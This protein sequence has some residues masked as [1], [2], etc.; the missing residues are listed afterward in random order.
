MAVWLVDRSASP[1]RLEARTCW[2]AAVGFESDGDTAWGG[3]E[4]RYR[5]N[6][7]GRVAACEPR[8]GGDAFSSSRGTEHN[9]TA[10]KSINYSKRRTNE[11]Q[12]TFRL[13][14]VVQSSSTH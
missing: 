1:F 11:K 8:A 9:S 13:W 7:C 12:P 6:R 2:T 10:F 3:E 14:T 5:S 4:S